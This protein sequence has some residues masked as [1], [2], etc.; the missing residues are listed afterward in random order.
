ME[1]KAS[2]RYDTYHVMDLMLLFATVCSLHI[3]KKKYSNIAMPSFSLR[4]Y[5]VKLRKVIAQDVDTSLPHPNHS[6]GSYKHSLAPLHTSSTIALPGSRFYTTY[7]R[8]LLVLPKRSTLQ[9][10]HPPF[11]LSHPPSRTQRNGY[12]L[13][14]N[15]TTTSPSPS[16]MTAR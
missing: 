1:S 4:H 9:T 8:Q 10:R 16:T 13:T 14:G 3:S 2:Y 15:T 11:S 12:P 5:A 7:L 6:F